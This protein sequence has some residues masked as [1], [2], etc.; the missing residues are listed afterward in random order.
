MSQRE[1]YI[2]NAIFS[3]KIHNLMLKGELARLVF[4]FLDSF[5][6]DG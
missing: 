2:A 5:D 1:P 4:K 6:R 3:A